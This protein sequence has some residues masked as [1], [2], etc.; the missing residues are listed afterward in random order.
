MAPLLQPARFV[1]DPGFGGL[2]VRQHAAADQSPEL[3]VIPGA[4]GHKL[5]EA[6]GGQAQPLGHR[7]DRL[8]LARHE[9]ALHV[10]GGRDA[11]FAAAQEGDQRDH[12]GFEALDTASP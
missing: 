8:A 5:L 11:L 9:Q 10:A 4:I 7:F 6:L 1:D 2:Q 12:E 3:V